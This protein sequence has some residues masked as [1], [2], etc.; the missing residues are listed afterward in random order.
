M[1]QSQPTANPRCQEE[2]KKEKKNS[3]RVKYFLFFLFYFI[4]F[5]FSSHFISAYKNVKSFYTRKIAKK[6]F[7]F[8]ACTPVYFIVYGICGTSLQFIQNFNPRL[9]PYLTGPNHSYTRQVKCPL[10]GDL[11]VVLYVLCTH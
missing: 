11:I 4:F 9:Q 7:L 8:M 5:F 1:P 10:I 2:E 6:C 3:V